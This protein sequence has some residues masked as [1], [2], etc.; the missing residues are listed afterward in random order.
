MLYSQRIYGPERKPNVSL[1]MLLKIITD[2]VYPGVLV[3]FFFGLTIF[4][5]EFGHFIVA[6]RRGLK[7]ERFS[8]GFGPKIFGWKKDGVEYQISWLLFG[9]FVA[10]PQMA[11][12][13]AF[14]GKTDS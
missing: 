8:I 1:E 7:I 3:A 6:K 2:W 14:E 5:H 12:L 9:G 11:P 4:I 13:E 10:L